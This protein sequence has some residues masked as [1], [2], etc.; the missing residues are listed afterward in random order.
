MENTGSHS[1][2]NV[3]TSDSEI[4]LKENRLSFVMIV[5]HGC[6]CLIC[7]GHTHIQ[8]GE[9]EKKAHRDSVKIHAGTVIGF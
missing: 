1:N 9:G 8:S 6:A 7:T 2:D 5:K 3:L 4:N